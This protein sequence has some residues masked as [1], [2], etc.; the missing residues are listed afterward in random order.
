MRNISFSMT[1]PQFIDGSKDV[2]RRFGWWF[3]KAGDRLMAVEKARGL[4]KGEQMKRLGV[5]EIVSATAEPLGRMATER[6][7]GLDEL[8]R[9]GY[10]FGITDPFDF[11]EALA[12]KSGKSPF[13]MVNRIEFKRVS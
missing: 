7:Y 10:P 2:T 12:E 9:E 8:R 4:K 6:E 5:I 13:E 1:T 11:V 3:L